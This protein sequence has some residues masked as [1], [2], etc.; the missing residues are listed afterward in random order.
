MNKPTNNFRKDRHPSESY[1]DIL[2]RDTVGAPKFL[3]EGPVP[4]IG[5]EPVA[6]SRYFDP[7]FFQKEVDHV[8]P[9]VWQMACREEEIPEVGDYYVYDIVGR[10]LIVVRT[11]PDEI[12]AFYNSCLHRARRLVTMNGSK[13]EF[14]CPYHGMKWNCDGTMKENPIAWDFPQWDDRD[15]SL[16]QA[17]VGRWGGFV[18]V[19]FDLEAQPLEL[20]IGPMAEHFERY[21]FANRYK[22]VHVCKVVRANWK[23][24]AEAFMESHHAIAT[25]PQLSV[26]LGD[27]N[28]QYDLLSDYISRQFTASGVTSP[29][30]QHLNYT[31]NDIIRAM[32]TGSGRS[33][34]SDS[35]AVPE[36]ESARAFAAKLARERLSEEDGWDYGQC[37]D[38]EMLDPMLYNVWP[39]MSFWAGFAPNIVYRWRPNG[40]DPDSSLMDVMILKRLPKGKPRPR[41][42]PVHN[43][44][45]DEPWTNASELGGLAGVFEQDEA[46]LPEVQKGL[47]ASGIKVVH[48]GRY[49]EMRIRQLHRMLDRHIVA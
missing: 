42:V 30:L 33:G 25:H 38:A 36:G 32:N 47:R 17:K 8:W 46:N 14:Y 10:S 49:T 16:P 26:Y 35:M 37:S 48:F 5:T 28:S 20:V 3:Y 40:L 43:L 23:A 39:H 24:T 4:N 44:D 19:N 27:V 45:A 13:K 34:T 18:F 1:A 6:A 9:R 41:P 21:D 7:V 22:A 11:A 2:D 15:M 31:A 29:V 12:K